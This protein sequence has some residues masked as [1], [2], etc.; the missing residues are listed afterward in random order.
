MKD[1][2]YENTPIGDLRKTSLKEIRDWA[3][4][5]DFLNQYDWVIV[6]REGKQAIF[7]DESEITDLRKSLKQTGIQAVI[8]ETGYGETGFYGDPD[9]LIYESPEQEGTFT[10]SELLNM[11]ESDPRFADPYFFSEY[12]INT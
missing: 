8:W 7:N 6:I 11:T 10:L 12:L 2:V 4:D 5:T 1:R 9:S 3:A